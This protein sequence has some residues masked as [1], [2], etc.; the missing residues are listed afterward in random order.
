VP[1]PFFPRNSCKIL[2]GNS[3][4][5]T[6]ACGICKKIV[7]LSLIKHDLHVH[8]EESSNY[9]RGRRG[10]GIYKER[11]RKLYRNCIENKHVLYGNG[12][13]VVIYIYE[14]I[15]VY[16]CIIVERFDKILT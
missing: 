16:T 11:G 6:S 12:H 5:A 1:N 4:R 13:F 7:L 10:R 9:I 2:N 3:N 14:K 15:N 8:F